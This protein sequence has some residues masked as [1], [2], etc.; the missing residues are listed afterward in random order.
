MAAVPETTPCPRQMPKGGLPCE[1]VVPGRISYA[2]C[3]SLSDLGT[4][5]ATL[6]W[7][8]DAG[9]AIF[10]DL[11]GRLARHCMRELTNGSIASLQIGCKL[12]NPLKSVRDG[13]CR[14]TKC[15]RTLTLI[16]ARHTRPTAVGETHG[17]S[18]FACRRS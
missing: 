9:C 1:L 5:A 3:V 6:S 2:D 15:V 11:L 4:S 7:A 14:A 17:T 18:C 16:V 10:G 12:S 13:Q 8:E